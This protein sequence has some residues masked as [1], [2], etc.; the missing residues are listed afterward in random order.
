MIR[1]A[2]RKGMKARKVSEFAGQFHAE[3]LRLPQS[4]QG[5]HNCGT[6]AEF[7]IGCKS[8]MKKKE[9]GAKFSLS[10]ARDANGRGCHG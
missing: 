9:N 5:A 7:G 3:S 2:K 1:K 6:A 4:V 8:F 10:K